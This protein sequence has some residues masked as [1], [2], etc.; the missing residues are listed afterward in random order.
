[1]AK[2]TEVCKQKYAGNNCKFSSGFVTGNPNSEDIMYLQIEKDF[3]SGQ[4]RKTT[5][6]F[7]PDEMAAIAHIASGVLWSDAYKQHVKMQRYLE[8]KK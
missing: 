2:Y 3:P 6:H 7:R 1:M 4:H 5:F 8:K